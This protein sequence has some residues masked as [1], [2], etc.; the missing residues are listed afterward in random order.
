[1]L[2]LGRSVYAFISTIKLVNS[3]IHG[4]FLNKSNTPGT[5]CRARTAYLPEHLSLPPVVVGHMVGVGSIF[6]FLCIVLYISLYF[7]F[8]P[9]YCN[10]VK[11]YNIMWTVIFLQ[12]S[13]FKKVIKKKVQDPVSMKFFFFKV[14][15]TVLKKLLILINI[16]VQDK[17]TSLKLPV[18]SE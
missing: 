2:Y 15:D 6:S 17:N 16:L 4:R 10:L 12:Q 18:V 8:W 3:V 1:L 9:K 5:T 7:F 13:H 14:K 11:A